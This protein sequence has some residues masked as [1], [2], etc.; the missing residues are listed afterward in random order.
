VKYIYD[1]EGLSHQFRTQAE[2]LGVNPERLRFLPP[3]DSE[4][5]HRANMQ[6]LA[7]VVLDT[8]PY[9]GATTTLEALWLGIPLVTRVGQ[10]FAAR[11]SYAFLTQCGITEGIAHSASEYIAWGVRLGT[12]AQLRQDIRQRL[13]ASRRTSPLWHGQR[14]AQ[15]LGQAFQAMWRIYQAGL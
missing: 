9:N 1:G 15:E 12:D 10:Q 13:L 7:D 3:V 14:F 4:Y 6:T 11:N 8:Y 5:V 2:Q